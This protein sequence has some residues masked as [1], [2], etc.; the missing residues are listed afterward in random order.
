MGAVS[1]CGE[2][3]KVLEINVA[4]NNKV[5]TLNVTELKNG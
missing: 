3:K 1:F 2:K 4:M 5:N